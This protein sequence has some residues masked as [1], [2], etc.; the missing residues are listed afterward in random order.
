MIT[1]LFQKTKGRV[2][3]Y[4]IRRLEPQTLAAVSRTSQASNGHHVREPHKAQEIN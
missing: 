2:Q 1:V 4:K 3:R